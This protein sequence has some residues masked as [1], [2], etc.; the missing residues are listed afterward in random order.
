MPVPSQGHYGFHSFP[1]VVWFFLFIYLWVLTFPLLDCSEFGN[2]VIT[3]ISLSPIYFIEN[4]V[5]TKTFLKSVLRY[6]LHIWQTPIKGHIQMNFRK[7]IQ[8]KK[9]PSTRLWCNKIKS[10]KVLR[11]YP[12]SF[13]LVDHD[14]IRTTW[15]LIGFSQMLGRAQCNIT[16]EF[17]Q[18]V[19]TIPYIRLRCN[20]IK[21]ENHITTF[22]YFIYHLK[23]LCIS[24]FVVWIIVKILGSCTL[25]NRFIHVYMTING[26][27]VYL[28]R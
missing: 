12:A 16:V 6:P 7:W 26:S 3:L 21:F 11:Y 10:R 24:K 1:V 28:W 15:S 19:N 5:F 2:F 27:V 23:S 22:T 18:I 4:H 13:L 8:F 25:S 17:N 20:V 9:K 14:F